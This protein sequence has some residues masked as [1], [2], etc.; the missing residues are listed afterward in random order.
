[1]AVFRKTPKVVEFQCA[2]FHDS[3]S[4]RS[5]IAISHPSRLQGSALTPSLPRMFSRSKSRAKS[6]PPP[7]APVVSSAS[8]SSAPAMTSAVASPEKTTRASAETVSSA[9][10]I[11]T[12]LSQAGPALV[13]ASRLAARGEPYAI[14]VVSGCR[15]AWT[16]LQPYHPQ[17]FGPAIV[18]FLLCFFGGYFATIT[19]AVEAYRIT[20]YASTRT[21]LGILWRNVEAAQRASL[22]DDELDEDGNGI[23]DTQE[24]SG[25]ALVL[26]KIGVVAKAVDPEQLSDALT[27]IYMGFVAVVATLRVHFAACVSLGVAVG[28]IVHNI[29]DENLTPVL[30]MSTPKEYQK[31]VGPGVRYSCKII[32]VMA[33][34]M[35]QQA[36]TAYHSA[37]RG[38]QL[39]A[40]GILTYLVRHNY[41]SPNAIDEKGTFFNL[42]IFMLAMTGFWTQIMYGFKLPFPL[43]ILLIPVRLLEFGLRLAVGTMTDR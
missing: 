17:E 26:R 36:I 38:A 19:A 34:W 24:I 43:N 42:A 30:M 20:G 18:G 13:A 25:K 28:D 9:L 4:L 37:T 10:P 11:A 3:L 12:V 2:I 40:R 22:K 5:Y 23:P 6:T 31:W 16:A 1:M 39:F 27:A 32:G 8:P 33:A 21:A 29:I 35:V 7:P 14:A 15:R 41:L